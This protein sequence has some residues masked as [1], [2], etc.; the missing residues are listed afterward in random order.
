M[1]I[2]LHTVNLCPCWNLSPLLYM[3]MCRAVLSFTETSQLKA[4]AAGCPN[5]LETVSVEEDK[6]HV[7]Q[8]S[9]KPYFKQKYAIQQYGQPTTAA[10]VRLCLLDCVVGGGF[11]VI[12][13][14][15]PKS[16]AWAADSTG[17]AAKQ[18]FL[19]PLHVIQRYLS[20]K[21]LWMP[22]WRRILS[23]SPPLPEFTTLTCLQG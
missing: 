20:R 19:S 22:A 7:K 2:H 9:G 4:I 11:P 15:Q 5:A 17:D 13:F 21:L 18:P 16:K 10:C 12:P 1:L 6:L 14:T 3:L 8:E 23:L